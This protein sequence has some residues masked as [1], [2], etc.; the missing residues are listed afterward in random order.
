MAI[1]IAHM[2][3]A[4]ILTFKNATMAFIRGQHFPLILMCLQRLEQLRGPDFVAEQIRLEKIDLLTW[5][6]GMCFV[7]K[8]SYGDAVL[9][10][11]SC[12]EK[13]DGGRYRSRC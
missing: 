9:I 7:V 10:D 11:F 13:L 5:F 12:R 4:G 6:S 3:V 8:F 1:C 2:I